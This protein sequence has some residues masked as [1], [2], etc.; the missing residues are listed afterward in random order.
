VKIPLPKLMRH[1]RERE[2]ERHL[3]PQA[4]RWGLALWAFAAR[5]P[6]LYR[7][8]SAA[9]ARVLGWA[10]GARGRFRSL[11]LAQG[12]TRGRDMPAPE[13]RSFM[14]LWAERRK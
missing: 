1:W 13:G 6:R 3:S 9:A 2:F 11:P 4:A 10:G 8:L 12:W 7:S 14:S 5:R